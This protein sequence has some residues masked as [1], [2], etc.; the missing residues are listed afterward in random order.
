MRD[1]VDSF[2]GNLNLRV[3]ATNVTKFDTNDG[4][5]TL[6][7]AGQIPSGISG[8]PKWKLD[9]K[10]TWANGPITA[11]AEERYVSSTVYDNTFT[12]AD[13]ADNRIDAAYYTTVSADYAILD[14]DGRKLTA[15]GVIDNLF[16]RDPPIVAS[17]GFTS[18]TQASVF[19]VLG[20]RLTVGLRLNY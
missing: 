6:H 20:R 15:F 7:T 13:I 12:A 19:D 18:Q 3:L 16:D 8:A 9:G 10:L 4:T 11:Y 2:A 5:V 1:F 14:G 17:T